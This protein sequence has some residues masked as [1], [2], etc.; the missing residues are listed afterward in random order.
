MKWLTPYV[1]YSGGGGE[2]GVFAETCYQSKRYRR[3]QSDSRHYL[4][5]PSTNK[6][7]ALDCARRVGSTE[8][9]MIRPYVVQPLLVACRD[10]YL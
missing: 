6:L 5:L 2:Y 1:Y 3:E 10:Y 9:L 8:R 4:R 7:L